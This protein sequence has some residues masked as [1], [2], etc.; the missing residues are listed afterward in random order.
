LFDLIVGLGNVGDKYINNRHNCGFQFTDCIIDYLNLTLNKDSQ[1]GSL[2]TKFKFSNKNV[3][4]L[5]PNSFMNLSGQTI[6]KFCN[7]YKIDQKNILIVHDE[8]DLDIGVVKLKRSGGH[9]GHNG[10]KDCINNLGNEFCRL[11]VGIGRPK[12]QKVADYVLSDHTNN[13]YKILKKVFEFLVS[14]FDDFFNLEF[15][16]LQKVFNGY[17]LNL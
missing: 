17:K 7:F 8:L 4:I 15:E 9:A 16:D 6:R 5:K 10:I 3:F 13:E 14:K 12:F 1:T 11:R 2:F